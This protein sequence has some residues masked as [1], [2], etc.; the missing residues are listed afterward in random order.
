[1]K[2]L[3]LVRWWVAGLLLVGIIG[4][5]VFA[6]TFFQW[7][8]TFVGQSL[9]PLLDLAASSSSF[10]A[11]TFTGD[12]SDLPNAA[13]IAVFF[14]DMTL[15]AK[16]FG[17]QG[18]AWFPLTAGDPRGSISFSLYS[19]SDVIIDWPVGTW[20][21]VANATFSAATKALAKLWATLNVTAYGTSTTAT[22]ALSPAI[23]GYAPGL[24][25]EL[26]GTTLGGMGV[27]LNGAFG[28]STVFADLGVDPPPPSCGFGF[29]QASLSLSGFP[30]GCLYTDIETIFSCAGYEATTIDLDLELELW[31][32]VLSLDG[33]L[34]FSLQTKS[35]T[36]IPRLQFTQGCVWVNI[37][38]EPQIWDSTHD[39]IIETLH[40]R[41]AGISG[42][43]IGTTVF[44]AIASFVGGLYKTK[45]TLD[46]SRRAAGYYV[47][48]APS[49]NPA[50][51]EQTGYELIVSLQQGFTNSELAL[52]IY[53]GTVGP[54]LFD[55]ALVT[56]EWTHQLAS[57]VEICFGAQLDPIGGDHKVVFGVTV[58]SFLP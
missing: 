4:Q 3:S 53:F 2:T 33:L 10:R 12:I 54:S 57:G 28:T 13:L 24:T 32:G 22:F 49:A 11:S 7:D 21:V 31:S 16:G 46:V 41:G 14:P 43:T 20:G 23:G 34:E 17:L 38:L 47:A 36:F 29:R 55:L 19:K 48:L 30:L 50:G 39:S 5:A 37:G 44:S 1:M 35:L 56:G 25:L 45:G 18:S 9:A 51:Y 40:V 26:A 15:S 27:R 58:E 6:K 42:E 52:D 8:S